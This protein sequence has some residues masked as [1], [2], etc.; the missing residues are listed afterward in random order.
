MEG[1]ENN[2]N[3]MATILPDDISVVDYDIIIAVAERADRMVAALNKMMLA[4]IKVTTGH[5][6][7]L[8]GGKPYLQESGATKVGRLFGISWEVCPGYPKR[9]VDRDGYPTWEYRCRFSMGSSTIECEGSR[10]G[11]DEFFAGK[12][13]TKSPDE[14]S[15]TNVKKSAYTNCINNGIK[16]LLP[17]L[18]NIDVK[19]LERNGITVGSGYTFKTGSRGG[20]SGRAEDSGIACSFCGAAVTQKVASFSQAKYGKILCM[21]CQKKPEAYAPDDDELPPPIEP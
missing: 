7:V 2:N 3:A 11:S 17:G 18:R 1:Y 14:V 20:N 12:D 6:W 5:D 4:A 13:K 19:D 21:S 8:V 9:S 15:E 16:R 10:D